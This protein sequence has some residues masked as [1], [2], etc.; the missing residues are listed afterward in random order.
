MVQKPSETPP[1]MNY[2]ATFSP[3][4]LGFGLHTNKATCVHS[5]DQVAPD[6]QASK[7]NIKA[8]HRVVAIN[9]IPITAEVTHQKLLEL[10]QQHATQE[11]CMTFEISEPTAV[12]RS[13]EI[14]LTDEGGR[15]GIL[16]E[17][18]DEKIVIVNLVCDGQGHAQGC[19]LGDVVVGVNGISL[20][21]VMKDASSCHELNELIAATPRPMTLNLNSI[22]N[23]TA[24]PPGEDDNTKDVLVPL[25]DASE[26]SPEPNPE[27]PAATTTRPAL[28][29][30]ANLIL[31]GIHVTKVHASPSVFGALK[32][33]RI[34]WMDGS[35]TAL[36]C[37]P[38]KGYETK[39][40]FPIER[41][42]E[43]RNMGNYDNKE[44]RFAV[45][46]KTGM[47]ELEV[48]SSKA[49]DAVVT[50][51]N[52]LIKDLQQTRAQASTGLSV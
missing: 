33:D 22:A 30:I 49:R 44:C 12:K 41:I 4:S 39:K 23:Q 34:L 16:T 24:A 51:L 10:L 25:V 3:G 6:S 36:Y 40:C 14:Q 18:R 15:I 27:N 19:E 37:A 42:K 8:G 21:Q 28:G 32:A 9:E 17:G 7:N 48:S 50:N 29:Q 38:E 5:I 43:I 1:C 45:V 11:F 35:M 2:R 20:Q 13:K 46:Y 31:Q 52:C 26:P 47:L